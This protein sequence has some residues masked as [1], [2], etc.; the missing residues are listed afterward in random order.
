MSM[1]RFELCSHDE[2]FASRMGKLAFAAPRERRPPG[3]RARGIRGES[4]AA[5]LLLG[6]SRLFGRFGWRGLLVAGELD[7]WDRFA[8]TVLLDRFVVD[9][10]GFRQL[11]SQV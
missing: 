4:T 8:E 6:R 9:R 3:M 7:V 1:D 5:F 11:L 10:D 2:A